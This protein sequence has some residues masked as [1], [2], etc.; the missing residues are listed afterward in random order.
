MNI[1]NFID[2]HLF[3]F[4]LIVEKFDINDID[5]YNKLN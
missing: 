3:L 5:Y 4:Y 2:Y 1:N